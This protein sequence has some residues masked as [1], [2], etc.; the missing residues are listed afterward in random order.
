MIL[1]VFYNLASLLL[2]FVG[3]LYGLF[4]TDTVQEPVPEGL[5]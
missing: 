2:N 1:R 5:R 3:L 4:C